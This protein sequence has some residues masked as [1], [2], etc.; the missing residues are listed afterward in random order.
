VAAAASDYDASQ[1]DNDSGVSGATV[2]DAL[3]ALDGSKQDALVSTPRETLTADRSYYVDAT[4]GDDGNNGLASGSGH[5]FETL[6]HALDA[7]ATIDFNG[8]T[9]TIQL[10]DGTYARADVPVCVGQAAPEYLVIQGNAGTPSNVIV[11]SDS[12]FLGAIHVKPGGGCRVKDLKTTTSFSSAYDLSAETGQLSFQNIV[13]AGTGT[14]HVSALRQA[15][16][17]ASGDYEIAAG[18][19]QHIRCNDQGC[20]R[21]TGLTVTLTGT[22]GF[23]TGSGNGFLWATSCSTIT[24]SGVTFVGSATGKRYNVQMNSAVTV[25]ATPDS[26]LPGNTTGTTAT[27]GQIG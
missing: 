11:D 10:A 7:I 14:A 9:V 21:T 26:Y 6:Q 13:F 8:Y 16:I 27:G 25:G 4:D 19:N 5:A 3:D 24:Y 1:V 20:F 2:K 18:A 15:V 12:G 22:P 17:L 23:S